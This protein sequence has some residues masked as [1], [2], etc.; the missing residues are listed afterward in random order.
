MTKY[1]AH[2]YADGWIYFPRMIEFDAESVEEAQAKAEEVAKTA[3]CRMY[4]AHDPNRGPAQ[5]IALKVV[6][7][8]FDHETIAHYDENGWGPVINRWS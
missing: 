7:G 1:A 4:F 6:H 5:L 2:V 8:R 3:K